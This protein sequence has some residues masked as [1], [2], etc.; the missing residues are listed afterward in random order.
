MNRHIPNG[1]YGGVGGR[2]LVAFSYPII[3]VEIVTL[4][5]Q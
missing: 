3:K 4:C 5:S 1:T 2:K